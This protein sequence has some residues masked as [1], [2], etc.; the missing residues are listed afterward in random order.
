MAKAPEKYPKII[1]PNQATLDKF[2]G[3]SVIEAT[4]EQLG[5][6]S[7]YFGSLIKYKYIP[8]LEASKAMACARIGC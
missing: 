4:A 3:F 1:L 8:V 6:Q 2:G 7:N 5:R